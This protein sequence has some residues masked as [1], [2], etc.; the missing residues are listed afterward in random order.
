MKTLHGRLSS[1]LALAIVALLTV[2]AATW[3]IAAQNGDHRIAALFG[4]GVGVYEGSEVRILGY[5]VGEVVGV[6]PQGRDVRVEM[7]VDSDVEIPAD[8]QALVI[9]SSLVA[10]R[11]VQ[12]TPPYRGGPTMASGTTIPRSRTAT[13]L[14]WDQLLASVQELTTAL[15]PDGA[16]ADGSLSRLLDTGADMLRGNGRTVNDTLKRLNSLAATLSSNRED[17]FGSV[18]NLRMFVTTLAE[19][20]ARV[21]ELT[22]RLADVVGFLDDEK[23]RFAAALRASA[24]ALA[25]VKAF[26]RENRGL[27]KSNV[28]KLAKATHA[29]VDQRGALVEILD[30][31]PAALNNLINA[32]DAGT[33]TLHV[34]GNLNELAEPPLVTACGLVRQHQRTDVP[35]VLRRACGQLAGIL[36]DKVA[37]PSAAELMSRAQ[38]G[39]LELPLVPGGR[40]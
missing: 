1:R 9:A 38:R 4:N 18:R 17:L 6:H 10:D 2:T 30:V 26:V 25:D 15:G 20:D 35:D 29:L 13:P 11:Y 36:D 32:Y 40:R 21:R 12:L 28:D 34:R 23:G 16:N 19:S 14:E 31:A 8:A 3:A 5:A 7:T 24:V 33:G 22:T 27:I 39:D 37:L